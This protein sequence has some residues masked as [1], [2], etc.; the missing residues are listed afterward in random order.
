MY[1]T[2]DAQVQLLTIW[3]RIP[4]L[5][6][7]QWPLPPSQLPQLT[8]WAQRCV[9]RNVLLASLGQLSRLCVSPGSQCAGQASPVWEA[10]KIL[11]CLATT[12]NISMLSTLFSSQIQNTALHQLPESKLTLS[13]PKPGQLLMK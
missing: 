7:K 8:H 6:P 13:Q 3:W 9:V 2:S 12:E 11:D 10:E 5:S 4:S 1:K